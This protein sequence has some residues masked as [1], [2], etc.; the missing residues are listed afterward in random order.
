MGEDTNPHSPSLLLSAFKFC[1]PPDF[2]VNTVFSNAE[3][4]CRDKELYEST[5]REREI[6]AFMNKLSEEAGYLQVLAPKG[7]D[8]NYSTYI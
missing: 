7:N 4:L 2:Q 8:I 3:M 6:L 5:A 1:F